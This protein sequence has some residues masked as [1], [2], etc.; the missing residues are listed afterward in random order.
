MGKQS[1]I[2]R[3][4][5]T[6]DDCRTLVYKGM[7]IRPFTVR[8]IRQCFASCHCL[9][10]DPVEFEDVSLLTVKRLP[11]LLHL[12]EQYQ[13]GAIE[14][15]DTVRL[16]VLSSFKKL[17]ETVF[18]KYDVFL[19]NAKGQTISFRGKENGQVTTLNAKEFEEL[20][21]L[22]LYQNGIDVSYMKKYPPNI[23]RELRRTVEIM[24][25]NQKA[26]SIEKLIDS[27]FLLLGSYDAVMRLPVR[28]FYNLLQNTQRRE[29]FEIMTSG[30]Y[31]AKNVVYWMAGDYANDPYAGLLSTEQDVTNRLQGL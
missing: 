16:G 20:S 21:E 3:Y 15:S 1:V 28:K 23:R 11:M 18:Q 10:I 22:I 29:N 8:E 17:Y 19:S 6:F 5:D 30:F 13:K 2:E 9:R 14:R 12:W 24:N 4:I 25:R 26:P 7:E 27:A 31:A